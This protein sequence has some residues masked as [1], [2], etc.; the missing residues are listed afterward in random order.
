MKNA[1]RLAMFTGIVFMSAQ[2]IADDST[3]GTMTAQQTKAMKDCMAKQ[4][5]A[6]STMTQA[7]ME[8]VCKN[9]LKQ[10]DKNGN[11]LATGPQ[12]PAKP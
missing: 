9:Q 10:N 5:A 6:N 11:D 3:S 1:I 12:T 4:K 7:A 2:A 8:T